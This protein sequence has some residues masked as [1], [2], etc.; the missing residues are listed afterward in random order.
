[1]KTTLH[2]LAEH[3]QAIWLDFISRSF[4]DGGD[5]DALIE[6]GVRGVTSNPSIFQKAIVEHDEYDVD[7]RRLTARHPDPTAIYEALA[8]ADIRRAADMLRPCYEAT[9]GLD[10]YVSLEVSPALAHDT[11]GSVADARRLHAAVDRPNLLVKIP[12]TPEGIPAI[13][14]ALVSGININ[15][16]LIFSVAQYEDTATAYLNALETRMA[17]GR[18]V[19]GIASV[20]SVFVSRMDTAVDAALDERGRKD[21]QGHAAVDN[22]RQAYARFKTL[23]A[24]PRWQRLADAGAR[25]QR[26]LWASTGTKNPEYSDVK[27]IE[28]LIGADTV[29]T[30]PVETLD[31]YR[32]HGDPQARIEQDVFEAARVL[33]LLPELEISLDEVTQQLEDEGVEKF[34]QPFDKLM[35]VLAQRSLRQ[36]TRAGKA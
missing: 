30:V 20:A 1:M 34:N 22:A 21:L 7:I 35:E 12:A 2:R 9:K 17:Q 5:F 19:R 16:T 15:V 3:G 8:I 6:K 4:L 18:D 11:E 36:E 32:D 33:S 23:F 27:Y 25:V 13:E 14:Q 26:P 31:A 24:G 10:G 28:A 29:N